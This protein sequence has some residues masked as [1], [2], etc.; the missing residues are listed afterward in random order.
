MRGRKEKWNE[1]IHT[2]THDYTEPRKIVTRGDTRAWH[3]YNCSY[4]YDDYGDYYYYD[5][6]DYYY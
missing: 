5:D 3:Y 1:S 4:H 2:Y 6:G